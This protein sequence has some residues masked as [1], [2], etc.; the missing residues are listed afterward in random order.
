MESRMPRIDVVCTGPP[1][2]FGAQLGEGL[3]DRIVGAV[4]SL[5]QF[6]AF[7][8]LQPWWL[9]FDWYQ[10]WSEW[11]AMG[12]L[13]PPIATD[14]PHIS[15][16]I[17]GM[18]DGASVRT[19][20]LYLFHALESM[21]ITPE[22]AIAP[23]PLA[24]C[25]AIAVPPN[26]A[27]RGGAILAHNL[28]GVDLLGESL[29]LRENRCAGEFRSLGLTCAPLSGLIDGVNEHGLAIT[30]DWAFA[31]DDAQAA[32]PVSVAVD[33]ALSHCRTVAEAIERITHH[34]RCGG[35]LLMLADAA[36]DTAALELS[37]RRSAVRRPHRHRPLFHSNQYRARGMHAV[38]VSRH[39]EYAHRAPQPLHGRRVLQSPQR[40]D[41]RLRN[42]VRERR[43][44]SVESLAELLADHGAEGSPDE[45]T[46][47]MHGELWTTQASMQF[48]PAKRSLRISY[49]P[50]CQARYAEFC[51]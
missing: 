21:A 28:D 41:H 30:Y 29:V 11:C 26:C 23:A 38:Q 36:G 10:Q 5:A 31:V 13:K 40:R 39:A 42:L 17:D 1:R 6:E 35:A 8:I 7:R 44:F 14:F 48:V 24:A 45:G 22:H 32:A 47:C 20:A 4:A 2:E 50:A 19:S 37:N 34:P 3:R 27:T 51:L 49:G 18:A 9:P 33:D 43:T 15:Q 25:S 46:I 16:R 12:T